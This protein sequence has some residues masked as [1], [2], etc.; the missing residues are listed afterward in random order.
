MKAY[1]P[2]IIA[3]SNLHFT[4]PIYQRLFEWN[5]DN[6]EQ[7][8]NDLSES[9]DSSTDTP[10]YIGMLTA[11]TN[12][13]DSKNIELVDG[14]QRF[15]ILMLLGCVCK[16]YDKRWN[17]FLSIQDGGKRLTFNS[18][19][20]DVAYL[21]TLI[22]GDW[23]AQNVANRNSSD[24]NLKMREGIK[25]I[26]EYFNVNAEK[27]KQLSS[28]IFEH[29]SFFIAS[30]PEDYSPK[31]LNTYFERM[32]SAGKSLENHEI[33]K[34]KLLSNLGEKSP[35]YINL[36]NCI[37]N[38]DTLLVR[39][40]SYER[41]EDFSQKKRSAIS[42]AINSFDVL[43]Q[44][45]I[46][47]DIGLKEEEDSTSIKDIQASEVK[48]NYD[49][50]DV[51][52]NH[53]IINFPSL[54][55]LTL[56]WS[57]GGNIKCSREK[58]FNT[59]N[60]LSMFKLHLPFDGS[61]VDSGKIKVFMQN[62]LFCRLVLDIC[63]IRTSDFG[64][65][66]DMNL[67]EG[68]SDLKK[69]LMLESMIYV[70]SSNFTNYRWFCWLMDAVKEYGKEYGTVPDTSYLYHY[71]KGKDDNLDEHK[72]PT[73]YEDMSFGKINRYWFWRLDFYIWLNRKTIFKDAPKALSVANNYTFIRN[74]SIEHIA[75]QHPEQ[76]SKLQWGDNDEEIKVLHSFGNLAMISQGL[77]SSL[78]NSAYEIKKAQVDAYCNQSKN[79]SIES[80]KL[81]VAFNDYP[82]EWSE[83]SI[84]E[85]GEKMFQWLKDSF[86]K[87]A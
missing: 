72:L 53:S 30:L 85:H 14:Q 3:E 43:L 60:L 24:I 2:K 86:K 62:L 71:L 76:D 34:V 32:N 57:L 45:N 23:Q 58:F 61:E 4:I 35:E 84:K 21:Q 7:L 78:S 40:R 20:K 51:R 11:K 36:W 10:Y 65:E 80:L 37:A 38:V 82:N 26:G 81:L 29:T 42:Y 54:L 48:P 28:Y 25:T 75:P 1:T 63:F 18:R 70:S 22:E 46:I 44:G 17:S 27:A 73:N 50:T 87:D 12:G 6:I 31:D 15:T 74:R 69:L 66:L 19:P 8:L 33:L 49:S 52:D 67:P 56:Y 9:M 77:N 64:Y 68:N 55:L 83:R 13:N 79:G 59:A 47:N 16:S 5:K 41:E 39:Q